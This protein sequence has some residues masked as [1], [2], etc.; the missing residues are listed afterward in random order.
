MEEVEETEKNE[1]IFS[2]RTSTLKAFTPTDAEE[3]GV[4]AVKVGDKEESIWPRGIK[5]QQV[6]SS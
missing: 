6:A 3:L 4:H 1:N 5:E 2:Q